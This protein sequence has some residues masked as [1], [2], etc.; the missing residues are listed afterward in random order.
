MERG[1]RVGAA[2]RFSHVLNG[3]EISWRVKNSVGTLT[4]TVLVAASIGYAESFELMHKAIEALRHTPGIRVVLKFHPKMAGRRTRLMSSIVDSLGVGK[5]PDHFEIS[6]QPMT[7]LLPSVDLLIYNATS[8]CYEAV[9]WNIPIVF[10]QSDIW[11]D[12]DPLPSSSEMTAGARTAAEIRDTVR[13]LLNEDQLSW[14]R[15]RQWEE[16]LVREAL[17]SVREDTVLVFSI[18]CQD[19]R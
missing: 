14:Q 4:K 15:R 17:C 2:L 10:V 12:L 5:L 1:N 19:M 9:A 13:Q 16:V 18:L 3:Q 6:E 11:F 7:E 8:V